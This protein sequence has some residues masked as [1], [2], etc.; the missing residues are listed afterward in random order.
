MINLKAV[1]IMS[2]EGRERMREKRQKDRISQGRNVLCGTL[3]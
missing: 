3:L 2:K 1:G